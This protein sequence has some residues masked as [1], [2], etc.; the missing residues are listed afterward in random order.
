MNEYERG[1]LDGLLGAERGVWRLLN[2]LE[3]HSYKDAVVQDTL[4]ETADFMARCRAEMILTLELGRYAV[5]EGHKG[6]FLVKVD[7]GVNGCE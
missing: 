7:D 2:G 6:P 1:F 4:W 5:I 3:V